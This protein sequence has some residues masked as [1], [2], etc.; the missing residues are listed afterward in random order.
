MKYTYRYYLERGP[1]RLISTNFLLTL[2]LL[3]L[4]QTFIILNNFS[5]DLNSILIFYS[6]CRF[7]LL[8]CQKFN[9]KNGI[10]IKK[11]LKKKCHY[12]FYIYDMYS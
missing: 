2:Q 4:G 11:S 10:E 7:E 8:I 1:K 12:S 9:I 5:Y 6:F 3:I